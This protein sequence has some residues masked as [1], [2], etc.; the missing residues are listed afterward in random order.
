MKY[1]PEMC[2]KLPFM[3]QNGEDVAEVCAELGVRRSTFYNWVNKYPEFAEAYEFGKELSEA[4]WMRMGRAGAF[5]KIKINAPVWFAIMRNKF[6][7]KDY[8]NEGDED[9]L[10]RIEIQVVRPGDKVG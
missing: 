8:Y 4:A 2:E 7:F 6:G 1:K 5:G 10:D 3:F 9:K